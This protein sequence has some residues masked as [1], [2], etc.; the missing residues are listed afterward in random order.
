MTEDVWH[1][2]MLGWLR[3]SRGTLAQPPLPP[4]A[5]SLLA[6]LATHSQTAHARE[7]LA[8]MLWPEASGTAS[9][10]SLRTT[11]YDLRR[12]LEPSGTP[13]GSVL[14]TD[15]GSARLLPGA[16]TT[17]AA[18]FVRAAEEAA[19][20]GEHG[21]VDA[22][23]R[24]VASYR[25]E[26]LAGLFDPWIF[27]ERRRLAAL[28]V[29]LLERLLDALRASGEAREAI[30]VAHRLVA[31]DPL[32]EAAHV[33]LM[34]L[35]AA[36]GRAGAALDQYRAFA[37]VLEEELGVEPPPEAQ[38]LARALRESSLAPAEPARAEPAPP[39]PPQVPTHLTRFVGREEELGR[40]SALLEG[41]AR[42]VTVAG[43]GGVGKTRLAAELARRA[44]SGPGATVVFAELA[45]V[46]DERFVAETLASAA[47]LRALGGV[48]LLDAAAGAL[49]AMPRPLLVLD[50]AEH[51]A[52]AVA[53]VARDLLGRVPDLRV[54]V[55]S[56]QALGVAGE[57]E[58]RLGPLPTPG[59]WDVPEELYANPSVALYV[60]RV[61]ARRAD[62]EL[63]PAN[64]AA[65][66]RLCTKL[67]GIPL[68][69]ELAAVRERV[70]PAAQLMAR[71]GQRFELLVSSQRD[72]P[73]RH[74]TLTAV[75]DWSYLALGPEARRAFARLSVFRGGWSLEAAEAVCASPETH[76]ALERMCEVSLVEASDRAGGRRFRMLETIREFASAKV[77]EE[78]REQLHRLHA[79]VLL[80]FA[81]QARFGLTGP[82]QAAWL[83]VVDAEF[84]NIRSA[85]D[86][87]LRAGDLVTVARI[88][89]ALHR[90]WPARS[91]RREARRWF[92]EAVARGAD[93]LPRRLL[94]RGLRVAG[95]LAFDEGELAEARR[96]F[97]EALA[98]LEGGEDP[99][100]IAHV[101]AGLGHVAARH[102]EF[103]TARE[104]LRRSLECARSREDVDLRATLAN[105]LGI[106]EAR[107]RNYRSA[108]EHFSESLAIYRTLGDDTS[109]L[110]LLFNLG[111]LAT[112]LGRFEEAEEFLSE[113][114]A[115][116]RRLGHGIGL[117]SAST[118]LGLLELR[119]GRSR[120]A[121]ARCAEAVDLCLEAGERYRLVLAVE[122]LGLALAEEGCGEAALRAL[123]HAAA[124]RE[125]TKTEALLEDPELSRRCIESVTA[126]VGAA[127]A[128]RLLAV[129]REE[130]TEQILA[131]A[132]PSG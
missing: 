1:I 104:L 16:F 45:G 60:D 94:E 109:V 54:L 83:E 103:D 101:L 80:A 26:F 22:L 95:E 48:D 99:S 114:I 118:F 105:D 29:D 53:D 81:E 49:A 61:R 119:R 111:Y 38:S 21:R 127:E 102:D 3:V 88:F 92:R 46:V 5:A 39:K 43:P 125:E 70:L 52:G 76:E 13:P 74:R 31:C 84:E 36:E 27:P 86:W 116:S 87:S 55:T 28:H 126:R 59:Q 58:L 18:E 15:R 106:L 7:E 12:A 66:A 128:E 32:N 57:T 71:L 2:D 131:S 44:R 82:E 6:Y 113:S 41:D 20:A 93:R 62:F 10:H 130:S 122:G 96:D 85:L 90:Y 24:A 123:G 107:T 124:L 98:L 75:I 129:G 65:V 115:T 9:R 72:V 132:P 8:A 50:N 67:E 34:R 69:L 100:T 11:L 117:A 89:V 91:R 40:L 47:G 77:H 37:G 78:E 110:I 108:F 63:T 17:D 42:L 14:A 73:E 56:R 64:A 25:G 33:S 120:E 35:Y 97:E 79:K 4:K 23:R 121:V 112:I 19:A 51:V 68:A 30:D